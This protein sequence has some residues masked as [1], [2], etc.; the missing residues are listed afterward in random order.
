MIIDFLARDI[1][2]GS[3]LSSP[4]RLVHTA[5]R[6]HPVLVDAAAL[7]AKATSGT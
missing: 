4:A 5:R 3:L 6:T 2:L 1:I 7:A